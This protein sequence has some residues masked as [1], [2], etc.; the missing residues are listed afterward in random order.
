MD[1]RWTKEGKLDFDLILDNTE[2][3]VNFMIG[4]L[5]AGSRVHYLYCNSTTKSIPESITA[6][7]V[8]VESSCP[9]KTLP[10]STTCKSL[11]VSSDNASNQFKI[12]L[13]KT[14]SISI[15]GPVTISPEWDQIDYLEIQDNDS[16]QSPANKNPIPESLKAIGSLYI[17]SESIT[18]IP[19]GL[20][21][22][23]RV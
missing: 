18:N 4:K 2:D 11:W 12:P 23:S 8:I 21:E 16:G 22:Y 5:A 17:N 15:H 1:P 19:N 10:S 7:T 6:E 3:V 14:N 13:L 9:L 20:K